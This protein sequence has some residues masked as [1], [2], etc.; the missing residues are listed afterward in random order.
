MTQAQ[1][2]RAI[3]RATGESRSRIRRIGFSLLPFPAGKGHSSHRPRTA[4]ALK[5]ASTERSQP[6][7]LDSQ[8]HL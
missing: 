6:P 2:E 1:L 8:G 4:E 7:V 3:C 5:V